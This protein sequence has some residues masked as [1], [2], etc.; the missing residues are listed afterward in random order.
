MIL[1][2]SGV[3]L[4][5]FFV[6]HYLNQITDSRHRATVLSFKGLS[7]NLAYGVIGYIYAASIANLRGSQEISILPEDE[8]SGTLFKTVFA[9]GPIY[10]SILAVAVFL[11]A[12]VRLKVS[13]VKPETTDS[14]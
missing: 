6:S 11:F 9:W 3:F 10:F 8:V 12:A 7:F 5:G 13:G 14:A 4:N 2:Y 1:I